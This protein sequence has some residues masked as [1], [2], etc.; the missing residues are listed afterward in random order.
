MGNDTEKSP[1][2]SRRLAVTETPVKRPSADVDVK[3]S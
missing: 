3:N 2:D 1:K